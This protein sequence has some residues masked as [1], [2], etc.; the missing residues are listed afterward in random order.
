MVA[1]QPLRHAWH[2]DGELW[3]VRSATD[4]RALRFRSLAGFELVRRLIDSAG[5]E[6]HVLDLLQ[7]QEVNTPIELSDR[8]TLVDFRRR[9]AEIDDDI[10]EANRYNDPHRADVLLDE[11]EALLSALRST[12]DRHGRQR[13]TGSDVER[14]RV[15]ATRAIRACIERTHNDLPGLAAHLDRSIRTGTYC[16]Y[17][18]ERASWT[19]EPVESIEP[20]VTAPAPHAQ[21][22][23]ATPGPAPDPSAGLVDSRA[24]LA[25]TA[26]GASPNPQFTRLAPRILEEGESNSW[27]GSAQ[28]VELMHTLNEQTRAIWLVSG[29]PGSGKS[30]FL[31]E[32][33]QQLSDN[34]VLIMF[35]SNDDRFKTPF[36]PFERAFSELV[37]RHE[38]PTVLGAGRAN[39]AALIPHL[40]SSDEPLSS[41][42]QPQVP[43]HRHTIDSV[44][45]WF[46]SLPEQQRVTLVIEDLHHAT[47]D[48]I[49]LVIALI[50]RTSVGLLLSYDPSSV[51][52][53]H[54][55]HRLMANLVTGSAHVQTVEMAP[56]TSVDLAQA[57]ESLLP[58]SAGPRSAIAEWVMT[59]A[60]GNP[61]LSLELIRSLS[62]V[63]PTEISRMIRQRDPRLDAVYPTQSVDRTRLKQIVRGRLT[64]DLGADTVRL[65]QHASVLG[66]EFDPGAL[67]AISQRPPTSFLPDL[68]VAVDRGLLAISRRA[69][70]QFRFANGV[71]RDVLYEDLSELD[72]IL[73]HERAGEYLANSLPITEP[74]RAAHLA[75]H[76]GHAAGMGRLTE[77]VQFAVQAGEDAEARKGFGD[78]AGWY[79]YAETLLELE[80]APSESQ[81]DA[82]HLAFRRGCAE[83]WSGLTSGRKTLLRAA[84]HALAEGRMQHVRLAALEAN[85]GM[86]SQALKADGEWIAIIAQAL[87]A[88][89]DPDTT[90]EL[91]AVLASEMLWADNA[92]NRFALSDAALATAREHGSAE[93]LARVLFRRGHTVASAAGWKRRIDE[94]DEQLEAAV[95]TRDD[96]L[97]LQAMQSC[98]SALIAA[99]DAHASMTFGQEMVRRAERLGLPVWKFMASIGQTGFLV[100]EGRLDEANRAIGTMFSLGVQAGYQE[101][102]LSFAADLSVAVARWRDELGVMVAPMAEIAA[103]PVHTAQ[104]G[105]LVG[106]RLFDAGDQLTARR[107]LDRV[108]E[109]GIESVEENFMELPALT[110]LAYLSARLRDRRLAKP[111]V[112]RLDG[113]KHCFPC[114]TTTGPCGLHTEGMLHSLLGDHQSAVACLSQAVE[115]HVQQ[116]AP[117][118]AIESKL[119]LAVAL[120]VAA[121]SASIHLSQYQSE[122]RALLEAVAVDAKKYHATFL[123]R[124]SL[125]LRDAIS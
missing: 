14:A 85:R 57:I 86:F 101:D 108:I 84:N 44:L 76:F 19:L 70:L 25:A 48:T 59:R 34:G 40:V 18:G 29:G 54:P 53:A 91:Q 116:G 63:S 20:I 12:L 66:R 22:S 102:A 99:G 110:N 64:S 55:S 45:S 67:A 24:Q 87:K 82:V 9:L 92:G 68:T 32:V 114:T 61:L 36:Q 104:I 23:S 107:V 69:P 49:S 28:Y 80:P 83:I 41:R 123:V 72:R 100:H 103:D 119:E 115:F 31:R 58:A 15:R 113:M 1:E 17:V 118:L 98:A 97:I 96:L 46:W 39:L 79:A 21:R 111:L 105:F 120:G 38:T 74:D 51:P 42:P 125:E 89:D 117:L 62:K 112:E 43:D 10:E 75:Y 16:S 78:A 60:E 47:D 88:S 52:P 71:V 6:V 109:H 56:L 2:A 8:Q 81:I 5:Q 11:R 30:R 3:F 26:M 37:D 94:A 90:A 50:Q 121:E 27:F 73:I 65:L 4:G 13:T 33:Q 77:A 93:T 122:R 35:G 124:R 106:P 7:L 95:D